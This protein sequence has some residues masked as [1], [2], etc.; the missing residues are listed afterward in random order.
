MII[1]LLILLFSS[2]FA[3]IVSNSSN[4]NTIIISKTIALL[5]LICPCAFRYGIGV[6]YFNYV[7]W[8]ES[9]KYYGY[10]FNETEI[11]YYLI[12]KLLISLGCG[13]EELMMVMAV[14]TIYFFFRFLPN[15]MWVVFVPVFVMFIYE[16]CFTTLRQMF[17]MSLLFC[18]FLH[19][20]KKMYI[21]SLIYLVVAYCFHASVQIVPL[22]FLFSMNI[23]LN[24]IAIISF[25]IILLLFLPNYSHLIVESIFY[26]PMK[27]SV[28]SSSG[29][30]VDNATVNSGILLSISN[31]FYVLLFLFYNYSKKNKVTI[32][33]RNLFAFYCL[34]SILSVYILIIGR[35]GKLIIFIL[36]LIMC[37][38]YYS[39]TKYAR[40]KYYIILS[41]LFVYYV[42][43][44]YVDNPNLIPYKTIFER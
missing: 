31:L 37:D 23:R 7:D 16:W 3:Y 14:L 8:F 2:T 9:Y 27:Y 28:Y 12:N 44:L 22:L 21:K 20:N 41:V 39:K 10:N 30:W 29:I 17:A 43:F 18:S 32:L 4:K 15:H 34:F 33:N 24:K 13:Y 40:L 19:Y 42:G 35:F 26:L 25:V 38:I 11:G 36:P 5:V 1:Y 6:D